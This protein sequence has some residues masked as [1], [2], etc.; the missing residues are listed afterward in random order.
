MGQSLSEVGVSRDDLAAIA[1]SAWNT[2]AMVK[3]HPGGMTPE[4]VLA[5]YERVY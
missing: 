4:S 5:M 1:D 2:Q 3:K